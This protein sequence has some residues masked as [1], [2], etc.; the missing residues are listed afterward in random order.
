MT[1]HLNV[2]KERLGQI[3]SA[4]AQDES[5]QT[6]TSVIMAG[7]TET[8]ASYYRPRILELWGRAQR[9]KRSRIQ[10]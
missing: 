7:W 1:E 3:Q 6:L 9:S 5:L 4:T 2:T 8:V 10:R